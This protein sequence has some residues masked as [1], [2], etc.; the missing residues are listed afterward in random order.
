MEVLLVILAIISGVI[1][2][3]KDKKGHQ[4]NKKPNRTPKTASPPTKRNYRQQRTEP[5]SSDHSPGSTTIVMQEQF[6]SQM[7]ELERMKR[8]ASNDDG[9]GIY[10]NLEDAL[11][12]SKQ[13]NE[14]KL[15]M[16]NQI[17]DNLNRKGLIDGIIMAEVLGPPR[18]R[19]AYRN[20]PTQ[21]RK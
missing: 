19:K 3:F 8:N 2:L 16:K 10:L 14:N 21:R 9:G 7:H 5:V 13:S 20:I 17:K 12:K 4:T 11:K 18:A 1:G 6:D 15:A